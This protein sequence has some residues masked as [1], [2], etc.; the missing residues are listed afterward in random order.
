MNTLAAFLLE[1]NPGNAKTFEAAP[2]FATEGAQIYQA[3]GCGNCHMV[4]GV[5]MKVGPSLNGV[6][7]R[8]SREWI[9]KHFADPPALSP[10]SMMPPFKFSPREMDNIVSYLFSLPAD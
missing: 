9:E 6:S 5:G 1:L 4:N 7:G 2:G 10:G 3:N 8:H